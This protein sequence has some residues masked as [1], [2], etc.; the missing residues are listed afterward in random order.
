MTSPKH[1]F[2]HRQVPGEAAVTV[3]LACLAALLPFAASVGMLFAGGTAAVLLAAVAILRRMVAA[4]SIGILLTAFLVFMSAGISPKR[5]V[6]VL[7]FVAYLIAR[8]R[9]PWL[10]ELT[11]W[12]WVGSWDSRWGN[13][14]VAFGLV[15]G[16]VLWAWYQKKPEQLDSLFEIIEGWPIWVLVPAGVVLAVATAVLEE[17]VYRGIVQASLERILGPGSMALVLQAA[18]FAAL[19][20]PSGILQGLIG[21]GLAFPYGLV[22]GVVRRRSGGLAVPVAAHVSTGLVIAVVVLLRSVA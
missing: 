20:F 11:P 12:P 3:A 14:G 2:L 17:A 5:V 10:R 7:A 16:L 21:T 18:V 8:S 15:S 19:H 9:L 13:A 22:L 6:F 4:S 1:S